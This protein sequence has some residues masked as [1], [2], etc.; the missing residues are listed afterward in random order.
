MGEKRFWKLRDDV[1]SD[2][3]VYFDPSK[4]VAIYRDFEDK[5]TLELENES[6]FSV[7]ESEYAKLA[8]W[9]ESE[10]DELPEIETLLEGYQ[11]G[12]WK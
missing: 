11:N 12:S 3:N 2:R 5:P 1:D 4:I 9:A 7:T 6:C 8:C 10:S